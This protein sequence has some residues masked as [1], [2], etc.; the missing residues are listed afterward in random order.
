VSGTAQDVSVSWGSQS[1]ISDCDNL[2][3][4]WLGCATGLT[5][6]KQL[7]IRS[8][9]LNAY[10]HKLYCNQ[11]SVNG[12]AEV[13]RVAIHEVGHI[14]G[15]LGHY[16]SNAWGRTRMS[17]LPPL[18]GEHSTY[19]TRTLARCDEAN[20]Q[21]K[22][23]VANFF[24]YYADCYDEVTNTNADGTLKTDLSISPTTLTLCSGQPVT[25]GGRLNIH[26]YP[27]YDE[28]G[29]N[30][31]PGRTL[32]IYKD[33]GYYASVGTVSS[34]GGNNWSWSYS[35]TVGVV[36][37]RTFYANFVASGETNELGPK[38]SATASITW[39]PVAQC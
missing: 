24:G 19:N 21:M 29:G 39:V 33:G 13:G 5:T 36:T 35:T 11:S 20:M 28:I 32:S 8:D 3:P 2:A 26:A 27:S 23:D 16:A 22:Y 10:S 25:F 4:D 18:K 6:P 17:P 9:P 34:G 14:G 12:C 31:L 30:N 37:T 15:Y 7:W 38:T 1:G